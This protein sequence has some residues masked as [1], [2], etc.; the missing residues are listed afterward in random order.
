MQDIKHITGRQ[1]LE[2][3]TPKE[4]AERQKKYQSMV[5]EI[6]EKQLKAQEQ[7]RA[8]PSPPPKYPNHTDFSAPRGRLD[9][10]KL[11]K[12]ELEAL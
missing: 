8:N 11:R 2:L 10:E 4:K 5:D 6:T 9:L 3:G 1:L 7:R 12:L